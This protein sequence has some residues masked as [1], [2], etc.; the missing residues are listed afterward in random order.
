MS[1]LKKTVHILLNVLTI[2]IVAFT[3]IMVLFTII[4]I[5]TVGK[6]DATLFGC[7]LYIVESD[8]MHGVFSAGDIIVVKAC[9]GA[10]GLEPGTIV[11]YISIDPHNYGETV[12]HCIRE[13]TEYNGMPAY[14]TYGIVTDSDDPTPVPAN[15]VIGT[16]LFRLPGAGYFFEFLR[17]PWG[18]VLLILLPFALLL[19]FGAANLIK[20]VSAY[21]KEKAAAAATTQAELD[22]ERAQAAADRAEAERLREQ[23]RLLQEHAARSGLDMSAVA[24]VGEEPAEELVTEPAEESVEEPMEEPAEVS[25]EEPLEEPVKEPKEGPAEEL[26]EEPITEPTEHDVP[27][28]PLPATCSS[29]DAEE[30]ESALFAAM[31]AR[32]SVRSY[33]DAPLPQAA[34]DA[35]NESIAA[36]NARYGVHM[37]LAVNDE[38]VFRGMMAR[39]GKFYGVKNYITLAGAP[40]PDLQERLGHCGAKLALEAQMLGLNTCFVALTYKK[41]EAKRLLA[42]EQKLVC[43]LAVGYGQ[44]Q[45]V[46]H[47]SKPL[48]AVCDA[49]EDAPA[50][51]WKGMEC[52]LLAPTAM[53]QQ[54][55][56][57]SLTGNTV[58][59]Q[60]KAGFYTELDLG[61]A[62]YF[63]ECGAGKE[64]FTWADSPDR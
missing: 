9:D 5:T 45:G 52:A 46:P 28:V 27:P 22:A 37:Q 2:L 14:I 54:R 23:L 6:D 51:F 50:W 56:L 44:T 17:T 30:G 49:S 3:V 32:H 19:G 21:K 4:S 33:T 25:A 20:Q 47:R 43:I 58:R 13:Q 15:N 8:S 38:R 62:K 10:E 40:A 64:N 55:F 61:I 35:L 42:G 41:R 59:A 53:N 48:S 7:R 36:C 60:A 29:D 16:Y 57:F 31:R 39:Y 34:I 1:A 24:A 26:A 63:F 12:T 18:Y 11:S